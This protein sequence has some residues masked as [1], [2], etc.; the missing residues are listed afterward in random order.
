MTSDIRDE[1][2]PFLLIAAF[3]YREVAAETGQFPPDSELTRRRAYELYEA[4]L[5]RK[6]S[7]EADPSG[8]R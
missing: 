4:E 2:D 5:R 1:L 3:A 8:G 7:D 6:P